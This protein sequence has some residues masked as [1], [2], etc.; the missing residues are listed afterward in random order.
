MISD[1]ACAETIRTL[2][3]SEV[4]GLPQARLLVSPCHVSLCV[5][6]KHLVTFLGYSG[7]WLTHPTRLALGV[8]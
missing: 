8:W 5:Q 6:Q 1:A 3:I 2:L 4:R 7:M